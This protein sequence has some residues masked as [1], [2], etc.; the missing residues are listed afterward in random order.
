MTKRAWTTTSALRRGV[1]AVAAAL[2][3]ALTL[4]S[5][6]GRAIAASPTPS[7]EALFESFLKAID[8]VPAS[9]ADLEQAFPDARA[10]LLAAAGEDARDEWTR[11]RAIAF[12]G[13]YPDAGVRA[14]L[15]GLAEHRHPEVRKR[16]VYQLARSFGQ[17]GDA[18]LLALVDR[19]TG[20]ADSRVAEAAVRGLRWVDAAGAKASLERIAASDR[21]PKAMR[22]LARFTLERRAKR[23]AGGGA[24]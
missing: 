22:S 4:S 14:A 18:A 20:D 9:R 2:T 5:D 13:F 17:P 24:R 6:G 10:R 19:A 1:L 3:L 21:A 23:L 11:T 7:P 16:A 12:L 8:V 15:V